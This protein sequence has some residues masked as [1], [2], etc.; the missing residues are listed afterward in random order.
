MLRRLIIVFSV[1]CFSAPSMAS[2]NPD[3]LYSY[4]SVGF[5]PWSESDFF[6]SADW[7]ECS[8][9]AAKPMYCSDEV[10]VYQS[11]VFG[12]WLVWGK[13]LTIYTSFSLSAFN[14]MQLGLRRDGFVLDNIELAGKQINVQQ[15]LLYHSPEEVDKQVI[16]LIAKHS[17]LTP[18][19]LI[20]VNQSAN[21]QAS[22]HSDKNIIQIKFSNNK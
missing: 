20:W 3:W 4:T 5:K 7:Y 10:T 22:W 9:D 12:E 11:K 8:E 21:T 13:S 1:C 17:A 18:R 14:Q 15:Q 2:L 19:I 6:A 16:A